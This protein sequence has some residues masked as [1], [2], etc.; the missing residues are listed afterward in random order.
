MKVKGNI[1][2]S[3][4]LSRKGS[5]LLYVLAF[6]LFFLS[7]FHVSLNSYTD[8]LKDMDSKETV[9]R[10]LEFEKEA[11]RH[12]ESSYPENPAPYIT[13]KRRVDYLCFENNCEISITGDIKY[14]FKY[15]I[16]E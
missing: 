12:L 1:M 9:K 11:I 14:S 5:I 10:H 13:A 15:V 2:K 16:I 4:L 7:W 3:Y 8:Y 6:Y